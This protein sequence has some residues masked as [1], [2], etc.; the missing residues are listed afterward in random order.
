M[1]KAVKIIL[2]TFSGILIFLIAGSYF[3]YNTYLPKD[4][5][6]QAD[7]SYISYYH[8]SYNECRQ[9]FRNASDKIASEFDSVKTGKIIVPSDTDNDL[10]IDWC[11]IPAK[12]IKTKL[13]II[14]SGLHGIE[15]Y[16]GNAIQNMFMDKILTENFPEDMGVLLIH[17]LNP[18]GFKYHHKATENNVDLNRNCITHQNFDIKNEGYSRLTQFL[19]PPQPVNA[20]NL[21]NHFFYLIAIKK[22]VQESMPVLRQ[23]A[24]QGQYEYE[25]GIYYG[26]KTNEPQIKALKP[27]LTSFM[28]D[29]RS[30]LNL[31]LHT[32][33]GERGKLHLFIDKPEDEN[34]LKAIE[35][36]FKENTIDWGSGVDFYTKTGE[37]TDW[38]SSLVPGVFCIPMLFEYGTLDSQTT[39]GSLKS[40]Q[41]MILENQGSHYGFKTEKDSIKTDHQFEE[42]YYPSS[43]VWRSKVIYD[44]YVIMTKMVRNYEL[45]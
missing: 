38:V 31:D 40:M 1:K 29:Y 12:G 7:P 18:Y 2:F 26:G 19:M 42:L 44:S 36:V 45:L 37:Y 15:G 11:Y 43:P 8:E 25:K 10:S 21:F 6:F 14:N 16:A 33:Y 39:F 27:V 23:A 17:G 34:I 22:I 35:F 41:I 30:V 24:L 20:D 32:G 28:D 13:L 3:A 5:F 4:P 9:V